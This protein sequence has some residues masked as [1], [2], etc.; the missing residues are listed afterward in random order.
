MMLSYKYH[1][2]YSI[3][4]VLDMLGQTY[5]EKYRDNQGL[6]VD[7][8][9]QISNRLGLTVK[10]IQSLDANEISDL[11][12]RQGPVMIIDAEDPNS[13]LS[14]HARIIIGI[15]GDC[16]DN[17]NAD[18]IILDPLEPNNGIAIYEP[19]DLTNDKLGQNGVNHI[20]V[21][22]ILQG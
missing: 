4:A 22:N 2:S 17:S 1:T 9:I 12:Q 14:L 3:E 7:E 21:Y 16:N 15:S 20:L 6:P 11:L 5:V 8:L 18:L 10:S 19:L 13:P